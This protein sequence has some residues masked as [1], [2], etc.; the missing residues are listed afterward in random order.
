M[1]QEKNEK[2]LKEKQ[3]K[4]IKKLIRLV[5]EERKKGRKKCNFTD[6]ITKAENA[7]KTSCFPL[8][9]KKNFSQKLTTATRGY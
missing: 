1:Q 7:I 8:K 2:T 3:G 6:L 9:K 5:N 4:K